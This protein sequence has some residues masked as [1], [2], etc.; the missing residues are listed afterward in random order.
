MAKGGK[1]GQIIGLYL[2]LRQPLAQRRFIGE[3]RESYNFV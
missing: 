1:L 3:L 2:A